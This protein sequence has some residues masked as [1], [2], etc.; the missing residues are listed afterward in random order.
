VS[1]LTIEASIKSHLVGIVTVMVLIAGSVYGVNSLIEKHD[2]KNDAKWSAIIAQDQAKT[3]ADEAQ[4][5]QTLAAAL[6]QNA[7]LSAQM[8]QRDV[9]LAKVVASIRTAAPSVVAKDL[10]G[11][12][13]DPTTVS[14]PIDTAR[15]IDT[16]LAMLPVVEANL[17]DETTKFNNDEKI[18]AGDKLVITDL[19][20]Q[21]SNFVPVDKPC[22]SQI[23]TL[24]AKQHKTLFKVATIV[25]IIAYEVGKHAII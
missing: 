17:A 9:A 11:T 22:A 19:Q 14:L 18:I 10:G 12:S 15:N 8:A 7:S 25:G 23:S 24:K 2:E 6:A 1:L 13:P 5:Q 21:L 4:L 3:N 20:T 16:Q